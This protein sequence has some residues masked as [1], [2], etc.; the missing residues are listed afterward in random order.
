MIAF[1]KL[2]EAE[3][4]DYKDGK[5]I[6]IPAKDPYNL[7][8]IAKANEFVDFAVYDFKDL[9]CYSYDCLLLK[10]KKENKYLLIASLFRELECEELE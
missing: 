6:A 10:D 2:T 9:K 4:K 5:T 8:P 1:Y 3:L 7:F